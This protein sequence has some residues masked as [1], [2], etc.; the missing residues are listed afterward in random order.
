MK[1]SLFEEYLGQMRMHIDYD[2]DNVIKTYPQEVP[3]L[4]DAVRYS[5]R[6]GKRLRSIIM[7]SIYR[8]ITKC[9][10]DP[11]SFATGIEMIH[12][13]SLVHDDLPCMDDDDYRRGKL[14]CH[15]KFGEALALLCGDALLT[16]AFECM[17]SCENIPCERL[18]K[19]VFEIAK[20]IGPNGMIGGQ[21]LDL[22]LENQCLNDSKIK[23]MY[24]MKTGAL[25]RISARIG[26]ILAGTCQKTIDSVTLWGKWFGYAYQILDDIEDAD[27]GG[28]EDTKA[29]L[30][31]T[32]SLE[33][34][35]HEVRNALEE[36]I[37]AALSAPYEWS[38]IQKLSEFYLSK[39]KVI[40]R[41]F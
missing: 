13:Y 11:M 33:Q 35:C 39:I 3:F 32:S 15:K 26:A 28:K 18:A 37:N 10:S 22:Y 4:M 40:E 21:V 16:M 8:D 2:I 20:A 41:G 29:T 31:K 25:F 7:L 19:A 6:G 14:S 5:L 27:E 9:Q 1:F 23:R 17:L 24:E 38:V 30:M 12:A 34:V 36:S